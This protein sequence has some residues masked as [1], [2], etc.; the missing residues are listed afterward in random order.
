MNIRMLFGVIVV[1]FY[2]VLCADMTSRERVRSMGRERSE[3][4]KKV[5]FQKRLSHDTSV[6]QNMNT[7]VNHSNNG[8]LT[9]PVMTAYM[10][11]HAQQQVAMKSVNTSMVVADNTMP[12]QRPMQTSGVKVDDNVRDHS[13]SLYDNAVS[14]ATSMIDYAKQVSRTVFR[15]AKTIAKKIMY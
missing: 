3:N 13:E 11:D 8:R 6:L 1:F 10:M 15:Y 2:S 7:P 9:R 14:M 4:S 5:S 12:I